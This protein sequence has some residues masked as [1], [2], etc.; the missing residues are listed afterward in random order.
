M[1]WSRGL[2]GPADALAR[3]VPTELDEARLVEA[4]RAGLISRLRSRSSNASP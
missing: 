3:V 4:N 1:T 2:Y